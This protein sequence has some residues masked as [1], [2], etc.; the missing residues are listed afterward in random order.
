M[1]ELDFIQIFALLKSK[2]NLTTIIIFIFEVVLAR[3][4]RQLIIIQF[5]VFVGLLP[6]R[7]DAKADK[8]SAKN[9]IL[10]GTVLISSTLKYFTISIVEFLRNLLKVNTHGDSVKE[11]FRDCSAIEIEID[12]RN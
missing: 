3:C 12:I 4:H 9:L 8:N 6:K 11:I 5:N 10:N 2:Q 1:L 7:N